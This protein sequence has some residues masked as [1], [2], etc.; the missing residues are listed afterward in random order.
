[1]SELFKINVTEYKTYGD[2]PN[3]F[4]KADGTEIKE[5]EEWD[6]QKKT[7][8]KSVVELQYGKQPP[9][10]EFVEVE[11]TY[12]PGR[13]KA[14]SY[15]IHTGTR[16]KPM[17][18]RIKVF[19]PC[20]DGKCPVAIDGDGC[21]EYAH[22]KE[23][24]NKFLD[25]GIAFVLFDR[26]E[27]AH[28]VPYEGRCQGAFYKTYNDYNYGAFAAWA[29]A[30]SRVVDAL[31]KLDIVDTSCI[32]FTGHS[33]GGKTAILAGVLDERAAIVNPNATCAGG[34][35]CNR[36]FIKAI[37][38]DGVERPSE[39]GADL[40]RT[41][42]FWMGEEYNEAAKD[43]ENLPF[44]SHYL[45]ALV[46]PRVLLVTEAGS[47]IWANPVGSWQTTMGA[48]EVYKFLGCEENIHWC[49]RNGTHYH[50]I[51]DVEKLVSVI[52]H[53]AYGEPLCDGFSKTPFDQPELMFKWKAPNK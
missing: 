14:N 49:F 30:Y 44:D 7:L 8:Y 15:I 4:L 25:N 53:T 6:E 2:L 46:A 37:G 18:F 12:L 50:G 20:R 1:M 24:L 34:C 52:R 39:M 45:K 32:T 43:P 17:Q 11:S 31:E 42:P 47:D 9:K 40:V 41:F 35:S 3:P 16:A 22:N 13:G 36:L 27:I 23:F 10:P 33:R 28:D 19:L 51:E 5:K 26:T 21:F 38:E 29:W 48:K